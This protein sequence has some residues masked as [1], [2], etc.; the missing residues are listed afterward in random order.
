[1]NSESASVLTAP[2]SFLLHQKL[3]WRAIL[4]TE[5]WFYDIDN[6]SYHT[7]KIT[8]RIFY[9]ILVSFEILSK[10]P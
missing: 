9:A 7:F 5:Y 2:H 8:F 10:Y 6:T 4:S 3:I 1:M